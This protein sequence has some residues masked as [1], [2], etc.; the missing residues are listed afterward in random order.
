MELKQNFKIVLYVWF[1]CSF[2]AFEAKS[3][4]RIALSAAIWLA[5]LRTMHQTKMPISSK[6]AP[7]ASIT[8]PVT[9]SSVYLLM[10]DKKLQYCRFYYKHE[11]E[12]NSCIRTSLNILGKKGW[13]VILST[14]LFDQITF[15][16][17]TGA[18]NTHHLEWKVPNR[19]PKKITYNFDCK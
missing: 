18:M 3:L 1:W 5:F 13:Y 7:I 6:T 10:E 2:N 11:V 15:S 8:I 4:I 14:H 12:R 16:L 9:C 17:T 19:R